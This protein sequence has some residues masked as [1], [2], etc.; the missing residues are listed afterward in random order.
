MTDYGPRDGPVKSY[1]IV[2][3]IRKEPV[4]ETCAYL[5]RKEAYQSTHNI[6]RACS[7]AAPLLRKKR[8]F[9]IGPKHAHWN[10]SEST[11]ST[12]N[13]STINVSHKV[14]HAYSVALVRDGS[15]GGLLNQLTQHSST[16]ISSLD[17][18]KS[19]HHR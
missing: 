7:E 19:K 2:E 3:R 12:T 9:T 4:I 17:K 16:I 8:W 6:L 14:G 13:Q 11:K 15:Q 1:F 5:T 18:A 10:Q